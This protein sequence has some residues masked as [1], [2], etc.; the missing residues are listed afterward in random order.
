ME[1][2]KVFDIAEWLSSASF[3]LGEIRGEIEGWER[4][5]R[6]LLDRA[7][8]E[9]SN[10]KDEV[11]TLMRDLARDL[12]TKADVRTLEL[13]LSKDK[14][15][16]REFYCITA[17][18]Q[19]REVITSVPGHDEDGNKIDDAEETSAPPPPAPAPEAGA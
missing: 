8:I 2:I 6:Y 5:S 10:G 4:A 11:A 7:G 14:A 13:A 1:P 16:Q 17:L 19:V 18:E 15:E 9:F 3:Q 12:H